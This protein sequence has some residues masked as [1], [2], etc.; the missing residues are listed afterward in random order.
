MNDFM[1]LSIRICARIVQFE[2]MS[3]TLSELLT[4]GIND[5][6]PNDSPKIEWYFAQ[7]Q[8]RLNEFVDPLKQKRIFTID[9]FRRVYKGKIDKFVSELLPYLKKKIKRGIKL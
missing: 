9:D 8:I 7:P 6:E 1:P 5:D 3:S 2:E 4:R